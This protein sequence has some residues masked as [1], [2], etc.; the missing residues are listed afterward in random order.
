MVFPYSPVS[1]RASGMPGV[2]GLFTPEQREGWKKVVD[3]VHH[4]GGVFFCQIWHQGRTTHSCLSGLE[5]HSS[6]EVPL[7]GK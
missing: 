3:G 6:S 1:I 5:P 4:K 7:G 2:P